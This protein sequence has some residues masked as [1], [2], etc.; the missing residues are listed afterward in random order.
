[1]AYIFPPRK[2]KTNP[3]FCIHR[4]TIIKRWVD[5]N[6]LMVIQKCRWCDKWERKKMSVSLR[7]TAATPELESEVYRITRKTHD[8]IIGNQNDA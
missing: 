1:M 6:Q 4:M 3:R 7:S 8:L 5:A 2:D